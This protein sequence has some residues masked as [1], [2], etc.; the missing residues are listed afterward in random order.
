M[1]QIAKENILKRYPDTT[2]S[3]IEPEV[4]LIQSKTAELHT[5]AD[6]EEMAWQKFQD[7]FD[8]WCPEEVA[9]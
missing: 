7:H 3:E 8:K 1:N 4:W 2:C 9:P 5:T 6:T